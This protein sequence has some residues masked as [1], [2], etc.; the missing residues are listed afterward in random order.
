MA[1]AK[2]KTKPRTRRKTAAAKPV[3]RR[4]RPVKE[5]GTEA[6]YGQGCRCE[7][8]TRAASQARMARQARATRAVTLEQLQRELAELQKTVPVP[9]K[10]VAIAP[11]LRTAYVEARAAADAAERDL[12]RA[13][14][15][16]K[17]AAVDADVLTVHGRPFATWELFTRTFFDTASFR[18]A[19]PAMWEKFQREGATRRFI[20]SQFAATPPQRKARAVVRGQRR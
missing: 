6:G 13:E 8:C 20:V 11:E 19:H 17:R 10:R 2:T 16:L 12:L 3:V 15:E 14:L 1:G 9:G 18:K 5:H 7:K 4:R